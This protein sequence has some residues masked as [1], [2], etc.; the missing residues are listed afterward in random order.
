M[1]PPASRDLSVMTSWSSIGT[2]SGSLN[3]V[4]R[5]TRVS[6]I[7]WPRVLGS[8]FDRAVSAS[9]VSAANMATPCATGSSAEMMAM[10]SG[11]GRMVTRRSAT[12]LAE[13]FTIEYGSSS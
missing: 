12:A 5:L 8:P 11:A 3:P 4:A 6:A 13:R 10:V 2:W 9:R 1:R 7:T